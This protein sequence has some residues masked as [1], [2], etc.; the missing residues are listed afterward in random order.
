MSI[1]GVRGATVASVDEPD[2]ILAATSELLVA[3]LQANPLMQVEEIASVWFTVTTDL[4]SIHPAKAARQ[5]GWDHT[6][7][8]CALE[9]PVPGSLPRCIRVLLHWNTS[10]PQSAIRHVYSGA[11]AS[12][13]PDLAQIDH[14]DNDYLV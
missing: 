9:I 13:R 3:I 5:L 1:R 10:L 12:L 11:A 6:P 8:M 4:T 14:N 2:A 7:L